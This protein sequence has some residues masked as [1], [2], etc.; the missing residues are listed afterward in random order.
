MANI[1]FKE[2][3]K[4]QQFL[5]QSY[6]LAKS[7]AHYYTDSIDAQ[8]ARLHI[9]VAMGATTPSDVY[10]SFSK[11]HSLLDRLDND[12]YKFRQVEKYRDF[13]ESCYQT[14][15]KGNRVSFHRACQKM[16]TS[17][18]NAVAT[19]EIDLAQQHSIERARSNLDFI[20][21]SID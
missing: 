9:L 14:L 18:Q 3:T 20:L 11:A 13:Y 4:A 19:G 15:S 2:Y 6:S 5:D 17:I 12:V 7:R 8:Q 21:Q 16:R 10:A 1:T